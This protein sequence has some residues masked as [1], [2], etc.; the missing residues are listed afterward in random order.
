MSVHGIFVQHMSHKTYWIW[1]SN[2]SNHSSSDCWISIMIWMIGYYGFENFQIISS[3][4]I[5][6]FMFHLIFTL[7]YYNSLMFH[8]RVQ[9][10]DIWCYRRPIKMFVVEIINI[11]KYGHSVSKNIYHIVYTIFYLRINI[12]F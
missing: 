3:Q 12:L 6:V 5:Y 7:A 10:H 8:S 1:N 2:S 11:V 4:S 9:L